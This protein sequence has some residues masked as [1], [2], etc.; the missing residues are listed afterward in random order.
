[1]GRALAGKKETFVKSKK[2]LEG[3]ELKTLGESQGGA[4][5]SNASPEDWDRQLI[6]AERGARTGHAS[7]K[8][9]QRYTVT[10]TRTS[11][12]GEGTRECVPDVVGGDVLRWRGG[13]GRDRKVSESLRALWAQG[14]AL[15]NVLDQGKA[16]GRP[17]NLVARLAAEFSDAADTVAS[18]ANREER[19]FLRRR[20]AATRN[21]DF[22][23]RA[24][25]Q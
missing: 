24:F 8:S 5:R 9:A 23:L 12:N 2:L 1:M 20:A 11:R 18:L 3:L 14:H 22:V 19:H 16:S 6:A 10:A 25:A 4:N 17:S 21:V 15:R 7:A 13:R